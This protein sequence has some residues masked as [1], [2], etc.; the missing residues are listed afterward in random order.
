[1]SSRW[2]RKA[3]VDMKKFSGIKIWRKCALETGLLRIFVGGRRPTRTSTGVS[4]AATSIR[5]LRSSSTRNSF[6]CVGAGISPSHPS[7]SVPPSASSKQPMAL[8]AAPVSTLPVRARKFRSPSTTLESPTIDRHER[9]TAAGEKEDY[10][11]VARYNSL[12]NRLDGDFKHLKPSS[13]PPS[14]QLSRLRA[15]KRHQ[16]AQPPVSALSWKQPPGWPRIFALCPVPGQQTRRKHGP[17]VAFRCTR[18]LPP[19]SPPPPVVRC[20]SGDDDRR[21]RRPIPAQGLPSRVQIHLAGNSTSAI[22]VSGW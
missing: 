4:P 11:H 17:L 21:P 10:G 7:S 16:I 19:R 22:R 5:T 1:M 3:Q 2:S 15:L 9:A 20:L 14:P 12:R 13:A 6:A 8:S 18:T